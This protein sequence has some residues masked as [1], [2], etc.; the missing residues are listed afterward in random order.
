MLD[1]IAGSFCLERALE[2][3]DR[4][5]RRRLG[6]E[7]LGA[8]A[9]DHHQPIEVV[10]GLE[11]P[12]VGDDLLGEILL[13]LA[14]LDVRAVEPLDVALVEH[15]RPRP[16]LLE[17]GPD[18]IEQRRL[19]ARRPSAPPRSSR[20]RRCPSR[21]TRDRRAPAS[22]TTSLIFGERPS[23]R[24]P[25]R[26]VP[27]CV[28]EPIGLANALANGEHAGN[29]RGADGAEADQQHA[30][31]AARRSNINGCRHERRS[32]RFQRFG[33]QLSRS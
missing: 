14:L 13:V 31:L 1:G 23:V 10:V 27:I 17:L 6:H 24:L 32:Y 8:A 16:D 7:D 9:P 18:L 28:S 22:G 21:R 2:A 15:R 26:I 4:L 19:D 25:R 33:C 5:V 12:D 30:E 11:L 3:L 29:G 20:P